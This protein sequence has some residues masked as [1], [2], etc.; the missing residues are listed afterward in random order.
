M[1]PLSYDALVDKLEGLIGEI[2][3]T[4][5]QRERTRAYFGIE[6]LAN[7]GSAAPTPPANFVRVRLE[8]VAQ[9]AHYF[10][11]EPS[12]ADIVDVLMIAETTPV[13]FLNRTFGP[14]GPHDLLDGHVHVDTVATAPL[15]GALVV[16]DAT[17]EWDRLVHPGV[18]GYALISDA[19][20]VV[21]DQTPTWTGLHT[22]DAGGL[23]GTGQDWDPFDAFGQ[24][25]GDA[26]HRWDLYTQEVYFNGAT[27]TNFISLTDNLADAFHIL[28][29]GD[30]DIYLQIVTTTGA[31]AVIFNNGGDDVDFMVE[32]VGHADAL[33]VQGSDGQITL[34]ALTQGV[35]SSSAGGVLSVTAGSAIVGSGA[36]TQVAYWTAANTLAGEAAF[37]YN[38]ATNVLSL[39]GDLTFTGTQSIR[40]TAGD[41]NLNPVGDIYFIS[42]MKIVAANPT[43]I[44]CASGAHRRLHF[45]NTSAGFRLDCAFD[46]IIVGADQAAAAYVD[47]QMVT[48]DAITATLAGA[49]A[50]LRPVIK[51]QRAHN[52]LAAPALLANGDQIFSFLGAGYDGAA[53]QILA[54]FTFEVDGVPA[55]GDMPGRII[56][57]TTP[58]GAVARVEAMRINS[59]RD[60]SIGFAGSGLA[61]L[62]VDQPSG[63]GA[64]PVALLDQGDVSE[65]HIVCT[66]NGADVDFPAIIELA[67]TGTPA[68]WWDESADAFAFTNGLEIGDV[69]GGNFTHIESDGTMEFNGTATVWNDIYFPMSS[70]KIGGA[71]QPTW[72]AFQ[73]NTFEYTFAVN[74]YIHLPSGEV[75]HS[76]KEGSD[77]TLHVHIVLD[78]S[79]AGATVVNYEVEYTIGDIDEVM[80]AAALA[81]SGDYTITGGTAD[82]THLRIELGTITGTDLLI[83]AALKMRFRRIALVGGGDAPSNDPFVLMVGAHIQ[84]DTVGSRTET[85]K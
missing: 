44:Y 10:G 78:G 31:E 16:A 46:R 4:G 82:R 7:S 63:T 1:S 28:D 37:T 14:M 70:G 21:W 6:V 60:V 38:A 15:E 3:D 65:Q 20:T 61:Q 25:L 41:L 64:Q 83:M 11:S 2:V 85:A 62:H 17:P 36:N 8:G 58:A 13:I 49:G 5:G 55:A 76:Y 42:D 67:V 74:N 77:I 75:L 53:Y 48:V 84:E 56:F 39:D 24:D 71:N 59:A 72:V 23:V 81:T 19:N 45:T 68:F 47:L 33:V 79:D 54:G 27:G 12:V 69:V 29:A 73:G 50:G 26:T 52:T 80:S 34:G 43:T 57:E 18:A 66:M 22:Y 40:T 9:L 51:M 32:V 30:G 35:V